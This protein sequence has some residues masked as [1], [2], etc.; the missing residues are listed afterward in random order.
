S[1]IYSKKPYRLTL[2]TEA[3]LIGEGA[4]T[5]WI[6]LANT[7]DASNLRNRII[8][9]LADETGNCW[10]P[11]TRYVDLYV[12]G[13]Y[14]GLYL[15]SENVEAGEGKLE[16]GADDVLMNWDLTS[17]IQDEVSILNIFDS[18]SAEICY[19]ENISSQ[20]LASIDRE[21][22]RVIDGIVSHDTD[23]TSLQQ[24]I[25]L[26]SWVWKYLIEEIFENYDAGA[27]S[28]YFYIQD[29][30][31]YSGPV[32]DYDNT[33][34]V[35]VHDNPACFLAQREWKDR[36]TPTPWFAALCDYTV[37]YDQ[38][39]ETYQ[40]EFLPKLQELLEQG[41]EQ[42]YQTIAAASE[43]NAVRWQS[44][45]TPQDAVEQLCTFL[46][47]RI[48]FLNSAWIDGTVYWTICVQP[49][50]SEQYRYYAVEDGGL[51][52]D[53]PDPEELDMTNFVAW[54]DADTG[55]EFDPS[56]PITGDKII[57]AVTAEAEDGE[58]INEQE[59]DETSAGY[60]AATG[61][62]IL[63]LGVLIFLDCKRNR[64][65]AKGDGK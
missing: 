24:E 29:E 20:R 10:N 57:Y 34:G 61:V 27:C 22:K 5:K 56:Q 60:L 25:D 65:G 14:R 55:E 50:N 53:L 45:T 16:L 44:G 48:A 9:R 31:I 28:M 12:N 13:E 19:P 49:D 4:S 54:Y 2:D 3:D 37:F 39:K 11:A 35:S 51:F 23:E 7:I 26:D 64:C 62:L 8:Y 42:Q 6:L 52:A 38:V 21:L 41:I 17:R 18:I 58:E 63:A 33:L 46:T 40:R 36:N 43:M 30:K 15:L 1:W 32:W 59:T 47:Q